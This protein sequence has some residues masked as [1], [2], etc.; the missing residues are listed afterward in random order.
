MDYEFADVLAEL[1]SILLGISEKADSLGIENISKNLGI[2][3][4]TL[5][6][7]IGELKKPGRDLRDELP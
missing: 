4:P 7:I 5:T 2:G 1:F 6:D 3:V